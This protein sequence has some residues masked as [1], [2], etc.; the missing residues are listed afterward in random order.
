MDTRQSAD[1]GELSD[2]DGYRTEMTP[3][4][5]R[6]FL[7]AT[8]ASIAG[9]AIGNGVGTGAAASGR[10]H[11]E[12]RWIRDAD[13]ND[14]RLQGMA[15]ADPGFYRRFHAKTFEEVLEWATDESRGWYPNVVRLPFTKDSV[16]HF[17]LETYVT[18]IM[19]PAVDLLA[20][21]GVYA[22][23][24]Y[25]LIRPYTQA[26]TD[27][28]NNE[29]DENL[30]PI[31][32]VMES[33][34]DRVASEF[35]ADEHVIFEL[36]NEPTQPALYGDD[37]GAWQTWREAAQPWVDLIRSHAAETPIIIGSPRWTSVTHMAPEYPFDGENLIYAGHIYPSN[38]RRRSSTSTT[39]SQRMMS[40]SLSRNSA[41]IQQAA[42]STKAL[43]PVGANRSVTGSKATG[44]WVGSR[45]VSMIRGHRRSSTPLMRV[46]TS[47]GR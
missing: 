13:G 20:T 9:L 35:A 34:W 5:R 30:D 46:P 29:N 43:P 31:N 28:Y 4:S 45:G 26:A 39:A 17:G 15:P 11:T 27:E 38:A 19:R 2:N 8:G 37:P 16:D 18:E 23:V 47:H 24:D 32:D 3:F 42:A 41:G 6:T 25:H 33:F 1:D 10:L 22:L 44:T 21:R 40:P 36:F 14:V 12:G 7:Q